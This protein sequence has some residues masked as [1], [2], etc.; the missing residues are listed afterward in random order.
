MKRATPEQQSQSLLCSIEGCSLK[1]ASDYGRRLCSEHLRNGAPKT[2][3]LTP[4]VRPHAEVVER[5][6]GVEF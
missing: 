1:W 4:A 2:V 6:D 5:E 3:P